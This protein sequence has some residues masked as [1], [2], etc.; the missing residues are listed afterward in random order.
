MA[1]SHIARRA[2]CRT[3]QSPRQLPP[4]PLLPQHSPSQGV[5]P[6]GPGARTKP[7]S[8]LSLHMSDPSTGFSNSVSRCFSQPPSPC[9]CPP[10][11]PHPEPLQQPPS[12]WPCLP[13]GPQQT[14]DHVPLL[15]ITFPRD[16]PPTVPA[17]PCLSDLC[18]PLPLLLYALL[19]S[20]SKRPCLFPLQ[21]SKLVFPSARK[22][23]PPT[24]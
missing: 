2:L 15:L 19:F 11:S 14:S 20:C 9:S 7:A 10:S 24:S 13:S 5:S 18:A 12:R 23:L 6:L 16:G 21:A 3:Q 1:V 17:V 22:V 8:H 4:D